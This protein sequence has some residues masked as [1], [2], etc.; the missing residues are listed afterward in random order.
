[1]LTFRSRASRIPRL[2]QR[3]PHSGK[4]LISFTRLELHF[5]ILIEI[6]FILNDYRYVAMLIY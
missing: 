6:F 1:M 2:K 5:K 3:G 4:S